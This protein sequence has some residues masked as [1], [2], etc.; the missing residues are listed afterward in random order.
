MRRV[1]EAQKS[2]RLVSGP[3]MGLE[4]PFPGLCTLPPPHVEGFVS[5][6]ACLGFVASTLFLV[7]SV[8]GR[9]A[10]VQAF[11]RLSFNTL[12]KQTGLGLHL[13]S[14]PSPETFTPWSPFLLRLQLSYP[15]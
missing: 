3:W 7:F 13:L 14:P 5:S 9:A 2:H 1:C 4:L 15:V 6:V 8:A 11:S 12:L 10:H